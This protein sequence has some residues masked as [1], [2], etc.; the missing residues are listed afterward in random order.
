MGL[1]I[2]CLTNGKFIIL[3]ILKLEN[4]NYQ[5]IRL[6]KYYR[7]VEWAAMMP[8]KRAMSFELACFAPTLSPPEFLPMRDQI[9]SY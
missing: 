6:F 8:W 3:N 5:T 4:L 2:L 1:S 7:A 9:F